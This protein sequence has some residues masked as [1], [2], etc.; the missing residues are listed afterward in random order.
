[1]LTLNQ[2]IELATKAHELQNTNKSYAKALPIL[3]QGF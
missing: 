1:M 2:A 3:L